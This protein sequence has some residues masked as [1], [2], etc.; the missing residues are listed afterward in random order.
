MHADFKQA[1]SITMNTS[2]ITQISNVIKYQKFNEN[3]LLIAAHNDNNT[4][5]DH[6]A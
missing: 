3:N 4:F 5:H 1:E 2:S 6:N